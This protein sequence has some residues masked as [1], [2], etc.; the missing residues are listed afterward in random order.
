M[1]EIRY[2]VISE[3]LNVVYYKEDAGFFI[4]ILTESNFIKKNG[5]VVSYRI[6]RSVAKSQIECC[7]I[8]LIK[9]NQLRAIL[10]MRSIINK[11]LKNDL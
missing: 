1:E 7:N 4:N 6:R 2:K 8:D 10:S 9:E 5:E 11:E 3:R